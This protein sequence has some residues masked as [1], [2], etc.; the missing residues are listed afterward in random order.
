MYAPQKIGLIAGQG[1]LPEMLCQRWEAMG[2]IPVIV[3]LDGI[4]D[5]N[6]KKN[7]RISQV[8]SIGQA[9][10]ILSFLTEQ[11][12]KNLTMVGALSRPNFWTLKTDAVGLSIIFKVIFKRTGDDRLLKILRH[13]FEQYNITV[14][15]IHEYIPELLCPP[16]LLSQKRPTSEEMQAIQSGINVAKE[17][18]RQDLGQSIIIYADGSYRAED[19]RGTNHLILSSP[20]HQSGILVKMSKPQQDLALDMPTIG[21]TTINNAVQ[22]GLKGIVVEANKTIVVDREMVLKAC[23]KHGLF[24]WG[25]E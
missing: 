11:S 25:W 19:K 7:N 12:V 17:H 6:L 23:D 22:V 3:L 13:T 20:P 24:F 18:G 15:G 14:V 21:I 16:G 2:F 8:F 10:K 9:G 1:P 5:L 4:S